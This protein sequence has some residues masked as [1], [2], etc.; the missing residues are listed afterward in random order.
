M[1]MT[2]CSDCSTKCWQY[3]R[4]SVASCIQGTTTVPSTNTHVACEFYVDGVMVQLVGL[5]S[6]M[7]RRHSDAQL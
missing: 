1:G 2:Y 3:D 4:L 6:V 7:W 5:F